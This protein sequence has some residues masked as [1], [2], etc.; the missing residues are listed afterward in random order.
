MTDT[1]NPIDIAV[2]FADLAD[3]T[4]LYESLGD[5]YAF[6]AVREVI[7]L[8][9]GLAEGYEGRVVKTIG[10][11]MMCVFPTAESAARAAGEMQAQVE[12]W[13]PL[14]TG[15]Q[16]AI[17]VGFRFGTVI[18]DGD[19]VFGDSVNVAARLAGL[20]LPG[21]V[22]TDGAT[23]A[24]LDDALRESLRPISALPVKGKAEEIEVFEF[25]W[26]IRNDRTIIAGRSTSRV[27]RAAD[28][29]TIRITY[30]GTERVFNSTVYLGR[31]AAD[32]HLIV[33]TPLTSRRH[34]KIELRA[35]KF[36]LMDQSS[37]GT[38][39]V[40]GTG[41]EIRLKREEVMLYASGRIAFG[42]STSEVST[43]VIAF[44]C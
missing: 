23:V 3:S 1:H 17:R 38:Y 6:R 19:D 12:P 18:P 28:V 9:R 5:A 8:L 30:Q 4:R 20:A 33:D 11:G 22:L 37:N 26:Q 43:D 10:D 14:S 29:P 34:A 25:L 24:R 39:V 41:S 7:N 42:V 36:V 16:L 44:T 13:P 31:E 27:S 21:Q 15:K 2:L 32:N 40:I 35:G